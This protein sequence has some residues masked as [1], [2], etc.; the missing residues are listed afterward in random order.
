MRFLLTNDDGIDSPGLLALVEVFKQR[1]EVHVIAPNAQRSGYGHAFSY[2]RPI[3]YREL[4]LPG[5]V[6][7]VA[8]EGTPVD[9]VKMG[10]FWSKLPFDWVI[11]G[12]NLGANVGVDCFYSGTVGAAS[13]GAIQGVPGVA[14]SLQT[15]HNPAVE[16][17]MNEHAAATLCGKLF[18]QIA[19]GGMGPHDCLSVNIP[20]IPP[21]RIRGVWPSTQAHQ[22]YLPTFVSEPAGDGRSV[23]F[24]PEVEILP[25]E[26]QDVDHKRLLDG[27][28]TLT[29]LKIDRTDT[30]RLEE[31]RAWT[32]N[33]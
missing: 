3:Y 18:D 32:W 33:V 20:A 23:L 5:G 31:L 8:V 25:D 4:T 17:P 30:D 29:P 27:W 13:E 21:N 7:A 10:L 14:F 19:A 26:S 2:K 9:C 6:P 28:I 16:N 15:F 24:R 1:G 11:S 22:R 12:L